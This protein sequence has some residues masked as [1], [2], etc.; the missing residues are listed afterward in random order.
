[1]HWSILA[2]ILDDFTSPSVC[3]DTHKH[4]SAYVSIRQHQH[5]S[6]YV[7]ILDVSVKYNLREARA[8]EL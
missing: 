6:A 7:G 2:G 1:M 8:E 4:T 3:A 5:T